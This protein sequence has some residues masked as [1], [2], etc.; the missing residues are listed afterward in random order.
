MRNA[1]P[2]A[3]FFLGLAAGHVI[4]AASKRFRAPAAP[5]SLF[6]AWPEK[7]NPKRG[8]PDGAPSRH[9][10]LRVRGRVTGFFDSTS[11]AGEKLA[12][13]PAGHPAGFPPPARRAIGAPVEQ[14]APGAQKPG[15]R[16]KAED[17]AASSPRFGCCFWR[18]RRAPAL[19]GPWAAVRWGRQ[20]RAAGEA[21]DG[22]AFSRG[23]ARAWMPELRQRRSSCPMPARKARPR[24]TDF[25]SMDG[26]QAPTGVSFSLGYFSF[27]QAKE[28]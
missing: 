16:A 14:R 19:R 9:P 20:G 8:H 17:R 3:E 12:G 5:E 24:L 2:G 10:A 26:R 22:L 28:K 13:I 21:I 15:T 11:C 4:L 18:A 23:Q 25:P 27:G 6:S 1:S 7:S